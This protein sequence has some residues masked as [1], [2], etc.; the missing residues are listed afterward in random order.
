MATKTVKLGD[1][2][3][4]TLDTRNIKLRD[5]LNAQGATTEEAL[6]IIARM[7]G[8]TFDE[9]NDLSL[10]DAMEVMGAFWELI[11]VIPKAMRMPSSASSSGPKGRKRT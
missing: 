10:E 11:Q 9:L 2:Q 8:L 5:V 6:Q 3:E 7:S 4:V 1:G